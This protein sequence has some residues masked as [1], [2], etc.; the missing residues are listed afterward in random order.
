MKELQRLQE[1]VHAG[2]I[3]ITEDFISRTDQDRVQATYLGQISSHS[4]QQRINVYE[5]TGL[6]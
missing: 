3:L 4:R 6:S 2:Q 1:N 5:I